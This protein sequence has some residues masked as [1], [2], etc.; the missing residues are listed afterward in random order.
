MVSAGRSST[1]RA[2]RLRRTEAGPG[3]IRYAGAEIVNLGALDLN[4]LRYLEIMV[5]EENISRAAVR[6]NMSQ[7]GLSSALSKMR[8]LLNDQLLVRTSSGM[9]PTPYAVALLDAYRG[10]KNQVESVVVSK[11]VFD[12][13]INRRTFRVE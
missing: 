13:N 1:R 3:R 7:P 12:P 11:S 9:V 4:F 5:E 6:L 2:R 10:F 8:T